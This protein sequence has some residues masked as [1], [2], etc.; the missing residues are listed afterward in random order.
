MQRVTAS[1]TQNHVYELRARVMLGESDSVSE[2]MRLIIDE[3]ASLQTD[4]E[5]LQQQYDD[6]Q[7]EYAA[8]VGRVEELEEQLQKRS[9]IE[10]DIEGVVETVDDLPAR[11]KNTE[12][13]SEKRQRKLDQASISQRLKWKITGV[14]VDED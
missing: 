1:L 2:S 4:Y 6:L 13:Y 5:E 9:N 12:S 8:R 11:I 10:S 14:P 7:Q 3:Y